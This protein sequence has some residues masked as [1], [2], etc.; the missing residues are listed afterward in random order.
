MATCHSWSLDL[1]EILQLPRRQVLDQVKLAERNIF[2]R[3]E[4]FDFDAELK[5]RNAELLAVFDNSDSPS[6]PSL[7]AY[8]VGKSDCQS[9]A[10][11]IALLALPCQTFAA[12]SIG[13]PI[14]AQV[15]PVARVSHTFNFT[16]AD[17]TFLSNAPHID[18]ASVTAPAWLQLDAST[19]TLFGTPESDY[20][21]SP[22]FEL[23]ATDDTGSTTMSV[24]LVVSS[25]P[26]PRLGESVEAQLSSHT[27]Y[28]APDKLLLPHS[29]ALS[30]SFS[31]DTF[32]DTNHDT[33]YYA[34]CAN[35]T[36]LPSWINFDPGTL[37]FS[38]T[39]PQNT[40]PD[41]LP[42]TFDIYFTA[43]DVVGF[44]AAEASFRVILENHI[45]TF[46]DQAHIVNISQGVP[47]SYSGLH[48]SLL[49]NGEPVDHTDIRE[50]H[51]DKPDWVHFDAKSWIIS[52]VPPNSAAI[53]TLTV[54]AT[55]IYGENAIATVTLQTT[56]NGSVS[57]FGGPL[58][59]VN[60]T[61]GGDFDYTFN[62]T[63]LAASKAMTAVGLGNAT[64]WLRFD[65]SNLELSGRVPSNLEP[66]AIIL[67]VTL[68]L[69]SSSQSEPLTIEIE[70]ATHSANS[71][72]TDQPKAGASSSSVASTPTSASS[73]RQ[74]T[75][76]DK[77]TRRARTAAAIAV[78]ITKTSG[79]NLAVRIEQE[80][81][82]PVLLRKDWRQR[83]HWRND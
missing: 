47:F 44:S 58:G 39:A 11:F 6:A 81:F 10:L 82:T 79:E 83:V 28:E 37:S 12:P 54:T 55:D 29:S 17:T 16:F 77:R 75:G 24:T 56:T 43:S 61:I 48:A 42:Q 1:Q 76:E 49:L 69:G 52:G 4:A 18:Y 63:T 31:P 8:A 60:A 26:G 22:S 2:P 3:N 50:V 13:L 51:A 45:L 19:R 78:P 41:E 20:P 14:N 57:L 65:Q 71:R 72:S 66:Q 53:Q 27:G 80:D 62:K 74:D 32:A 5:K 67:N 9:M 68:T 15:P 25:S 64:S 59:S 38:G 34:L 73:G 40:S 70:S 7:A 36:P 21:A 46:R 30:V 23:V 33:V 35:N